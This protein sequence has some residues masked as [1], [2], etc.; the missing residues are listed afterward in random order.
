M[1]TKTFQLSEIFQF[2]PK[3]HRKAGDG[4]GAGLYPFFTSSQ[5]QT[6]WFDKADY[7]SEAIIL[8]TGGAPSIHCADNF[9]TSADTFIIEPTDKNV[10]AKYVY[11][12]LSGNRNILD[13]GFKGAGLRH[14]S[15][16]Y[17]EKIQIPFPVDKQGNPDLAEQKRIVTTLEEAETLKKKRAEADQKMNELIPALFVQMFGDPVN[18]EKGWKKFKLKELAKIKIGPF[19]SLLHF[20][21]YVDDGIPLVNPTHIIDGKI[22]I[23]LK[24]TVTKEKAEELSPYLMRDGD[25]VLGRRGEMGRCAMVTEKEDGFL[26]GTGSIFISPLKQIDQF[27]LYCVISSS[28][29]KRVLERVAKGVTM[30]NLNSGN[31]EDLSIYLPPLELQSQFADK[32][33]EI[34]QQKEKQKQSAIQL[35]LLFLALLSKAFVGK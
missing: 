26:C 25:I 21:D 15:K 34:E 5:L 13:R 9:S 22:Q 6:K 33:K 24:L 14:L 17:T 3:S 2:L 7:S 28:P 11:Y 19:G 1:A 4:L 27:F 20:G 31:V 16:E 10:L 35:D 8:G 32:V 12:F 23:D 29:I 30:K 18:N